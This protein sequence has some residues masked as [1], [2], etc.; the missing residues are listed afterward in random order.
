MT[1]SG[2]SL[3]LS[4]ASPQGTCA[5]FITTDL[6]LSD[7][8]FSKG[9]TNDWTKNSSTSLVKIPKNSEVLYAELI[10]GGS[11]KYTTTDLTDQLDK[12]ISFQTP[13]GNFN[14]TPDSNTSAQV[15]ESSAYVRTANVTD[16]V[17]KS[18]AGTYTAGSIP[19]TM[20]RTNP[21]NNYAGWTLAIAYRDLTQPPR[22]LNIFVGSEQAGPDQLSN[23]AEV[24]GFATPTSGNISGRLLVSAQEGDPCYTGDQIKFGSTK[25]NLTALSGPNNQKSNFFASQING[26]DGKINKSGGFGNNNQNPSTCTNSK[27]QGWDV[28]NVDISTQLSNNQ[29]T[30][31]AQG[32]SQG[33]VY[34]INGLGVQIDVNAAKPAIQLQVD[35]TEAK[36]GDVLTYTMQVKNTGTT[37]SNNSNLTALIPEGTSFVDGSMKVDG[38]SNIASSSNVNLGSIKPSQTVNV[39]YQVKIDSE[40]SIGKFINQANLDYEYTMVV[41]DTPVKDSTKSNEVLTIYSLRP[42]VAPDATDDKTKTSKNTMVVV[43]NLANDTDA[44]GN[45]EPNSLAITK[46]PDNGTLL[47]VNGKINYTPK[48]DFVGID[49]FTYKICDAKNLCDDAKVTIEVAA[50]LAANDDSVTTIVNAPVTI[51]IL[52]NDVYNS[53]GIIPQIKTMAEPKN[54]TVSYDSIGKAIYTPNKD[55]VGNDVFEYQICEESGNCANAFVNIVIKSPDLLPS[56]AEN[57]TIQA[58]DDTNKTKFNVPVTTKVISD[59]TTSSNFDLT[60][61]KI[62][63]QPSNGTAVVENDGSVTYT[64]KLDFDSDDV[65]IYEICNIENKCSQANLKI[66]VIK[67]SVIILPKLYQPIA[68]EDEA[69]TTIN[70]S[71][72]IPVL[73]NDS[74]PNDELDISTIKITKNATNGTVIADQATG[75]VSYKP[76]LNYA[77]TD[78]FN[79]EICNTQSPKQCASAVVRIKTSEMEQS[80]TINLGTGSTPTKSLTVESKPETPAANPDNS[81]VKD[82]KIDQPE[83]IVTYTV[84]QNQVDKQSD[85]SPVVV[86]KPGQVLGVSEIKQLVRTGGEYG[87]K[88]FLPLNILL[89]IFIF[90]LNQLGN[91]KELEEL[92]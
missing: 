36:I 92:S 83:T 75:K 25:T 53:I 15:S 78:S 60:K 82:V 33:D 62:I 28:T 52:Q 30:A 80:T 26:D 90:G 16:I 22:N 43:D 24:K 74:A 45:L 61:L 73:T 2:N 77:G 65:L 54:G 72:I 91:K 76:N 37:E 8:P 68:I 35:K 44:D 14:I 3:C 32:T 67:D 79:Y 87:I 56:P 21:Y 81:G 42:N 50:K 4:D 34:M 38:S 6:S 69:T 70:T 40:P 51:N 49:S 17:S 71:V 1:F 31:Y 18:G 48:T 7:A 47:I 41:G 23:I 19:A 59:D 9:T 27:R 10:W 29:T 58:V 88:V 89:I 64:P 85:Q 66:T 13:S 84:D 57:S 46:N 63:T 39:E 12:P 11:Y 86:K 55:Y 20:D 5:T